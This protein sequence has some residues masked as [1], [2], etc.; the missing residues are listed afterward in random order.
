MGR[1]LQG[2]IA[3]SSLR[4]AGIDNSLPLDEPA[5]ARLHPLLDAPK[6]ARADVA[7]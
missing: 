7:V 6:G 1:R 3:L 2:E 4:Q 5:F